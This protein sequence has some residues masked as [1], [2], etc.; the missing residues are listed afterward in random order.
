M[1]RTTDFIPP[2]ADAVALP[3]DELGLRLLR[4]FVASE[5]DGSRHMLHVEGVTNTGHWPDHDLGANPVLFF[6]ALREAWG[7]LLAKV[8]IASD[9]SQSHEWAFVTR[10]GRRVAAE[11]LPLL[12]AEER[13]DVDLHP[14]LE[15]VVRP[16]FL[17]GQYDLAAFAAMKQVE[18]R[19]RELAGA[20]S[21][22][23]GVDLMKQA[24]GQGGPLRDS[25]SDA[26]EQD[27][28]MALFWGAIGVFKN[29]TSHRQVEFTDPTF[30]SEVVLLADLLMRMLDEAPAAPSM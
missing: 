10:R 3:L 9:P 21:S 5:D 22:R 25:T 26:G 24:F 2:A 30:A 17:L 4:L 19:V 8:L 29:P 28:T 11:G 16:Q 23:L 6:R 20:P 15:R 18:I 12:R 7:W 1:P 27:A 14:S 13:L